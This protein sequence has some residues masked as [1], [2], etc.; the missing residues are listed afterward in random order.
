MLGPTSARA[1]AN[2]MLMVSTVALG[3]RLYTTFVR[4]PF[5]FNIFIPFLS[6]RP[7][8]MPPPPSFGLVRIH[9]LLSSMPP[10]L[11]L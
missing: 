5:L 4:I 3:I 11:T 6:S 9:S 1:L 10:L 8:Q 2:L 7:F